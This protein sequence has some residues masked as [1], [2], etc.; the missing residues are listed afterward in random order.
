MKYTIFKTQNYTKKNQHPVYYL[1]SI[2]RVI[3]T[4]QNLKVKKSFYH[5]E[6]DGHKVH[7]FNSTLKPSF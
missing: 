2:L 6:N 7:T 3:L 4:I 1:K 5:V